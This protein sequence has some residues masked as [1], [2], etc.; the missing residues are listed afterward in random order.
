MKHALT[1]LAL[2]A[3]TACGSHST[4][5][6]APPLE[7]DVCTWTAVRVKPADY[8][9]NL[10]ACTE[11]YADGAPVRIAGTADEHEVVRVYAGAHAEVLLCGGDERVTVR[12]CE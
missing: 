7:A 1:I 4:T 10:K 5:N 12:P 8:R 6:D 9:T 3:A 2:L 11:V